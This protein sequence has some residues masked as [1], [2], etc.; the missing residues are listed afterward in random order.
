MAG[1]QGTIDRRDERRALYN[2]REDCVISTLPGSS[3]GP[4]QDRASLWEYGD[5]FVDHQRDV[6]AI[7]DAARKQLVIARTVWRKAGLLQRL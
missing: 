5:D 6:A 1:C 7:W 3:C 2:Y 4:T